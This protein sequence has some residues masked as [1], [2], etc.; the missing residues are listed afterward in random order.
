MLPSVSRDGMIWLAPQII[1]VIKNRIIIR[2]PFIS[3]FFF[4]VEVR[5]FHKINANMQLPRMA[6]NEMIRA[7]NPKF[8]KFLRI[9]GLF[10]ISTPNIKSRSQI[11]SVMTGWRWKLT[12]FERN[13][14]P[15][16]IPPNM[17][18]IT[19]NI[20]IFCYWENATAKIKLFLCVGMFLFENQT[21]YF[22][23]VGNNIFL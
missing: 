20:D 12:R 1:P 9:W 6:D 7:S 3:Y 15:T 2:L 16:P 21:D 18:A 4:F 10:P 14:N 22:K 17:K 5:I 8:P 19:M 11:K 13:K 23:L